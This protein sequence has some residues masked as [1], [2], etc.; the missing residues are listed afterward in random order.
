MGFISMF[1]PIGILVLVILII[2]GIIVGVKNQ[3]GSENGGDEVI[4]NVY[5]YIVLFATLMMV[6][7]GSVGAFMAIADII[8]PTSYYQS[9][10]EYELYEKQIEEDSVRPSEEQLR[11]QYEARVAAD[12]ERN[13][14]RAINSLIKSIGW[15]VI[16]LPIFIYFQRRLNK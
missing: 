5:V 8:S 3:A 1:I 14:E 4:K 11:E 6:I 12:K 7:G 15:I 13:Q 2:V 10:D 16:P 9:F